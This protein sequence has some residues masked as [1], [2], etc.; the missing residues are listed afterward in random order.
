[1]S[2]AYDYSFSGKN[3]LTVERQGEGGT[4]RTLR[5]ADVGLVIYFPAP[6]AERQILAQAPALIQRLPILM[7]QK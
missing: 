3:E 5:L 7:A 1:L 4:V 2:P 6:K